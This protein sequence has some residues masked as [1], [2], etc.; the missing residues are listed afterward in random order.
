MLFPAPA[1]PEFPPDQVTTNER[2]PRY[3]DCTQ[4]GRLIATSVPPALS[5]LW[6]TTL[7]RHP[8]SRNAS[9]AG[10]HALFTRLTVESLDASI[11]VHRPFDIR[12]G[13]ELAHDR[14]AAGEV[15]KL[16]SNVWAEVRGLGGKSGGPRSGGW[17]SPD[18]RS[19]STRSPGRSRRP[20]SAG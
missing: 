6:Q 17:C 11:R 14:D 4:D 3:E 10:I 9:A 13:F 15:T 20:A 2:F 1:M 7:A 8:G 18:A 12:A 16:Y 5:T 19:P